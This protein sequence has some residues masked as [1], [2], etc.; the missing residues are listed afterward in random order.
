[1][2]HIS[3]PRAPALLFDAKRLS[4]ARSFW[5]KGLSYLTKDLPNFDQI[6]PELKEKLGFLQE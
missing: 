1:M 3:N 6:V 4:E 2:L 5:T